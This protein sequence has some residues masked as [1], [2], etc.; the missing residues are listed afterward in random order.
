[1]PSGVN[2]A[3]SSAFDRKDST[4]SSEINDGSRAIE[5][6][7]LFEDR[8]GQPHNRFVLPRDGSFVDIMV[9]TLVIAGVSLLIRGLS[10]LAAERTAHDFTI[11]PEQNTNVN[12]PAEQLPIAAFPLVRAT[13]DDFELLFT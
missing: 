3:A 6:H 13:G 11:G 4:P 10:Q 7:A 1:M 5:V 8:S 2:L 9:A 12:A